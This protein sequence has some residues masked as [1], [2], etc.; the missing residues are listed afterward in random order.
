MRRTQPPSYLP[1]G[2][3]W[4]TSHCCFCGMLTQPTH[5]Q[6][7]NGAGRVSRCGNKPINTGARKPRRTKDIHI[8]EGSHCYNGPFKILQRMNEIMYKLDLPCDSSLIIPVFMN[9]AS[10]T[11][12]PGITGIPHMN[13]Y[14]YPICLKNVLSSPNMLLY[15]SDQ[16]TFSVTFNFVVVF[17]LLTQ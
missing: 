8:T 1:T 3:S 15:F 2:A 12:S 10:N 9:K 7:M 14:E 17:F 5:P 6:W 16:Q 13:T 11:R 4:D